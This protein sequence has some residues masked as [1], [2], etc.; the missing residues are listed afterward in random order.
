[1]GIVLL[2]VLL[3]AMARGETVDVRLALELK[4]DGE[5]EAAA[6]QFR[7]LALEEEADAERAS[8]WLW[9]SAHEY[10]N[11]R[12]WVQSN[13]QLDRAEERSGTSLE[14]PVAWLR[15]ENAM[16]LSDWDTA[17]FHF[18]SMR[19]SSEEEA[20]RSFAT[21]GVAAAALRAGDSARAREILLDAATV[22]KTALQGL[23]RYDRGR[24]KK[25]WLGGV[26]GIIPGLGFMYS[27]EYA[28]G[29][30]S[31]ILNGLFIWGMVET[32]RRD[33]WGAFAA[34]TFFEL[35]WFSGSIYGGID[36]AERY[37]QRRLDE[38][39]ESLRGT[40]RPEPTRG[41]LPLFHLKF[42]F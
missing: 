30:R 36:S 21:R 1:M 34:I 35:T 7:R 2:T 41:N 3:G 25:P 20:F 42:D 4:A 33:Q 11:E 6:I 15:A 37:N 32:G 26:L 18:E 10:A 16:K 27:G 23:D 8:R 13:R 22:P 39:V 29:V 31:M 40:D 14:V 38:A 5:R 9:L 12:K 19:Q 17:A 24:D 28:N